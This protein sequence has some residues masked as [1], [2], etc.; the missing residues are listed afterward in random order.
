MRL[1]ETPAWCISSVVGERCACVFGDGSTIEE[2]EMCKETRK[3]P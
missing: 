1:G 3:C 2:E